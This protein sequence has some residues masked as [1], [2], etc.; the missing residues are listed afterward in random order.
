VIVALF[1]VR[2]PYA[3]MDEEFPER[4]LPLRVR[5]ATRPI[6]YMVPVRPERPLG[7]YQLRARTNGH[8]IDVQ[9]Y[10]GTLRPSPALLAV[11]QRQLDR[12]VVGSVSASAV[13]A[14]RSP[15]AVLG[16]AKVIDRTVVCSVRGDSPREIDVEAQSGVRLFG[17]STKW[18]IRPGASFY[19]QGSGTPGI[20][21][22]AGWILAGWPP[23]EPDMGQPLR[24]EALSYSSR[25]RPT[26]SRIPLSTAGLVGGAASQFGEEYDCTVRGTIV[27]RIRSVFYAPT[28][29][30]RQRTQ[31]SDNVVARGRVRAASLA[32]RTGSGKSIALATAHESGRSRLFVGDS[33]GP[34]A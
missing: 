18:R 26:T 29:I 17:D 30:R 27:V 1:T 5:D 6:L 21:G 12:L 20:P 4:E 2:E 3:W 19:V 24:T 23:V 7:Q 9:F 15:T 11:A 33:C 22:L 32:I 14:A 28:S 10:F 34:N 13:S 16:T 31:H 8:Y 25:C